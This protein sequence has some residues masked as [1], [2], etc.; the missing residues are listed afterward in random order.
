MRID[1][2]I[3]IALFVF[4]ILVLMLFLVVPEYKTFKKLQIDLGEKKAQYN[5]QLEYY[6]EI[7]K[8]YYELKSRGDDLKKVDNALPEEPNLGKLVYFFQKTAADSGM[9]VKNL[10]LSGVSA[11]LSQEQKQ[12]D[13]EVNDLVFS[14]DLLGTYP[15]LGNFLAF[16]EKSDRIFETTTI[17]FDAGSADGF[18]ENPLAGNQIQIQQIYSFNLQIKT[19]SY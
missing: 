18:L 2:P 10:F 6:T 4:I 7:N 9:L 11:D 15:S 1:R 17:S 5:A 12:A 13:R 8:K 19:H 3:A 16:L 14:I